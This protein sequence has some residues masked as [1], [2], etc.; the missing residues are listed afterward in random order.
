MY[1]E[2]LD[3]MYS[4]ANPEIAEYSQR[5]FKTG[6][7]E[8]GFGDK[9]LG[10]RVPI[11]RKAVKKYKDISLETAEKIL[12]SEYHEIRMFALLFF[13]LRFS[14]ADNKEQIKIYNLYLQR[15]KYI[16]NW[17][18]I[19]T[20]APHI[21]GGYLLNKDRSILY[22]FVKSNSLW[23]RRIAIVATLYFIR[24]NQFQDTIK[25]AKQ[26]LEDKEDLIHKAT[27]WAL[28]EVG[29]KDVNLLIS[30][31]SL[32]YKK[33]P[34]TMLRYSIEKFGREDRAKYLQ[35]IF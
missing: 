29:K 32:H 17:D 28:R 19:D 1:Q 18:L 33:M 25:L 14:K 6:K 12:K 10:I 4:L 5:F 20:T 23:E 9:F 15:I 3:Y 11:I 22:D 13:V 26:L 27:G 7:G 24:N 31:L 21:V 2:I 8:Y 30:F 34:R 16:N 35:G